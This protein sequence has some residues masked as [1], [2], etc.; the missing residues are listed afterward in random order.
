MDTPH[1]KQQEWDRQAVSSE[2]LYK[3]VCRPIDEGHWCSLVEDIKNKLELDRPLDAILDVGCGNGLLLSGLKEYFNRFNGID[4]SNNMIEQA[5]KVFPEANFNQSEAAQ[6][7]FPDR[8]FDRVISYSIFHYF[9]GESYVLSVLSEMMRVCKKGGVVL[10]G[11]VLDQAFEDQV[12]SSS[13]F[14]Y[15]TKIPEIQRYSQWYFCDLLKLKKNALSN[16][17][18]RVDIMDQPETFQC[19]Q[20]R[21][22]IRVWLS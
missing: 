16:G 21:K 15:E 22:D 14:E 7:D 5:K 9:E 2:C 4:Y 20:Y 17:A 8:S 1:K 12:K 6:L 13:D 18:V 3:Q 11:D 19:R 10:I